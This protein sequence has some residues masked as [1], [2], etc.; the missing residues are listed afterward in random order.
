MLSV[1][2]KGSIRGMKKGLLSLMAA[3]SIC[4]GSMFLFPDRA[5]AEDVWAATTGNGDRAYVV[6]ES[7]YNQGNGFGCDVKLYTNSRR[8]WH[9][10]AFFFG[11]DENGNWFLY[12]NNK[13]ES[14]WGFEREVFKVASRYR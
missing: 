1:I 13:L 5:S 11:Q 8:S 14:T 12:R 10:E 4:F 7:V 3:G 2:K 6:S 9:T